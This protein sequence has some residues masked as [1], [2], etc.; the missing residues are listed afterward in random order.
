MKAHRGN[1][2]R[3]FAAAG[4]IL[5]IQTFAR[6]S[7]GQFRVL[8]PTSFPSPRARELSSAGKSLNPPPRLAD[9]AFRGGEEGG[10]N[11]VVEDL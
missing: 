5:C 6:P 7:P 8:Q 9:P 1:T 11:E 3:V 10:Q 2:H 4:G